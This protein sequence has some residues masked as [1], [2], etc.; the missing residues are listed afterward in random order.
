MPELDGN[1]VVPQAFK[2]GIEIALRL[3]GLLE[4]GRE[5]REQCPDPSCG[6]KRFDPPAERVDG[7]HVERR[8]ARD[9][10]MSEPA[11]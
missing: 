1:R 10:G 6:G 11:V 5:L 4:T 2:E 7:F 8:H 3:R 9:I